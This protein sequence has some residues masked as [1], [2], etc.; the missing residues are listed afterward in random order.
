MQSD[1]RTQV[2]VLMPDKVT[3]THDIPLST[4]CAKILPRGCELLLKGRVLDPKLTLA[5]G[6]VRK[7]ATLRAWSRFEFLS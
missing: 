7:E 5:E 3:I 6:G 2:F 4:P 1:E